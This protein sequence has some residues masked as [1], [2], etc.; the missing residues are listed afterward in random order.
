MILVPSYLAELLLSTRVAFI[1]VVSRACVEDIVALTVLVVDL[2]R[3]LLV[4]TL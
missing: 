1:G 2:L 3:F 4:A